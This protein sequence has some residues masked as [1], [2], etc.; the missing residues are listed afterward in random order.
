MFVLSLSINASAQVGLLG[1]GSFDFSELKN[2]TL[3]IPVWEPDARWAKK[4]MKRGKFKDLKSKEEQAAYYNT[5]WEEAMA[6][7]SY[8]ATDYK[9][10]GFDAKK[11]LKEKNKKVEKYKRQME[12]KSD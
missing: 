10:T 9:I 3:Y 2:K 8:D 1:S 11:L 5:I 12:R 6:E 4:M 7:S